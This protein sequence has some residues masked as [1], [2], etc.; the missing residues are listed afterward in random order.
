MN[1]SPSKENILKKI[2]QALSESTPLPFPQ[3]EGN[4]SVFPP[5]TQEPEVEFA[6]NFTRLGGKFVYCINHQELASH[7]NNL[8]IHQKWTKVFCREAEL[9]ALL[10][11]NLFDNFCSSPLG[12]CDAAIT[13]CDLLVARTGSMVLTAANESGRTVS[14]YAP[15]HI[16]IAYTHQLVFDVKDAISALKEKYGSSLPSFI[17]FATGP[18]RTADIEKTLVVGVH[19]PKEVYCFLVDE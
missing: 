6:E 15:I 13:T 2:R 3:S 10:Q 17:S 12:E 8:V 1:I 19:G 16:C 9:K 14:V 7:L 4:S 18:S 11:K 5:A